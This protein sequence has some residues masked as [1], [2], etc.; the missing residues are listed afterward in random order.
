MHFLD[1]SQPQLNKVESFFSQ[2]VVSNDFILQGA[3]VHNRDNQ[4]KNLD[5]CPNFVDLEQLNN[6]V[7]LLESTS[8]KTHRAQPAMLVRAGNL[9]Y[10]DN[11]PCSA[12]VIHKKQASNFGKEQVAVEKNLK[13]YKDFS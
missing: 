12:V 8:L 4:E 1:D 13:H 2:S 11:M 10:T 3:V 6:R 7:E 5:T 9:S